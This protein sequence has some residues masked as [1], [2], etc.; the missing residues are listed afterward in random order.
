M[1]SLIT[2]RG[3]LSY[4]DR[5]IVD[6]ARPLRKD[7][8]ENTTMWSTPLATMSARVF[9]YDTLWPIVGLQSENSQNVNSL[10]IV[11]RLCIVLLFLNSLLHL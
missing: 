2:V 4:N 11:S 10:F 1:T 9:D 8:N 3:M 6:S 5:N 7:N